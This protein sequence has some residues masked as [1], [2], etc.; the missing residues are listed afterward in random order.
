MIPNARLVELDSRNHLTLADEPAWQVLVS[1]VRGF[2]GSGSPP[3]SGLRPG[4]ELD[5]LTARELEVLR[6]ISDGRSNQEI[7]DALVISIHTVTNHVKSILSKTGA[8][9]RT[10]AAAYAHRRGLT[11]PPVAR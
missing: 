2:L 5:A 1:E 7:A 9:N 8:S 3:P 6:L 4:A 11:P 10:E